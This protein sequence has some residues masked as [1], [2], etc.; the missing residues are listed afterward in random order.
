MKMAKVEMMIWV[1]VLVGYLSQPLLAIMPT[2]L[3]LGD[4][5]VVKVVEGT[6]PPETTGRFDKLVLMPPSG[7]GEGKVIFETEGRILEKWE[8][9]SLAG[10]ESRQLLLTLDP[11]GN[12]GF[13][14]FALL[15]PM[16]QGFEVIWEETMKMG[17]AEVKDVNGDQK[18]DLVLT[19]TE[20]DPATGKV[21]PQTMEFTWTDGKLLALSQPE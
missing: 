10:T 3:N 12:G 9:V 14:E 5:G 20:M 6:P 13:K 15:V 8:I 17:S 19:G 11:G 21:R 18:P 1:V 4:L 2:E 7:T 16:N